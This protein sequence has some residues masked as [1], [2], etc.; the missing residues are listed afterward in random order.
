MHRLFSFVPEPNA[1]LFTARLCKQVVRKRLREGVA[2]ALRWLRV[3]PWM[4]GLRSTQIACNTYACAKRSACPL[5]PR[6]QGTGLD[7]AMDNL[8]MQAPGCDLDAMAA[9]RH[10]CMHA[11]PKVSVRVHTRRSTCVHRLNN[12]A[13]AA[14]LREDWPCIQG[15]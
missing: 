15:L 5:D 13:M 9:V 11:C 14:G 2:C 10:A 1:T 4:H 8:E 7:P 12:A 3:N 6:L